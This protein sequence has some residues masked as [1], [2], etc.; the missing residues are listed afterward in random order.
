MM[1]K[2]ANFVLAHP[3]LITFFIFVLVVLAALP[4]SKIR[5]DFDLENFYPDTDPTVQSYRYLEEEFGRDDNI[6]MVGFK[7]STFFTKEGLLQLKQIVDSVKQ[8][9]LVEDVRSVWSA[10]EMV[11]N[12]GSLTIDPF[13]DEDSLA[14]SLSSAKANITQDPFAAGFFIDEG[15]QTTA[16]YIE[17]EEE[18]NTYETR[19]ALINEL[20]TIL[21][22][23]PETDFKITGIP[24]FRN[25][26]VNTL[27]GEVIFYISFSSVLIIIL[28]W[29]LYRSISGV[30][31]PML[32]VWFTVLFTVAAITFT[33]GYLEIMSS[34]IAPILL[35]VGVADSIH[36]ISKFDD[37]IQN[38]FEKSKAI[39]EMLLTLGSATFL[40]SITTAIGFG[41]L[42]TSSVVPMKRFGLYT[43]LGVLIAYTITILFLP[44]IIKITKIDRVFKENG[45]RLYTWIAEK[46][47]LLSIFN[48]KYFK[49][50]SISAILICGLIGLGMFKLNVNG[51]VFDDVSRSSVLIQDSNFFSE[52]LAP[53][54]PLEFVIDTKV[55]SGITDPSLLNKVDQFQAHLLSYPEIKRATSFTT[56][57]KELHETMAPDKAAL[58]TI[59]DNPAL[60]SQY[61][62]LLEITGNDVLSR[63]TDFD[64]QK[65]RIA[66]QTEDAGS[67]RINEI[68]ASIEEYISTNFAEEEI[69]VLITGSTILSANLVG[70]MVYSLA[71]SIGLAFICISILMA[72]LFKDLKMV[73]ISLIPNIMPLVLIAGIMGILG[74]DIKPSTAVIFTIAFGIAVDDT[75]HY[76]AR[77]RIEL[78]R[79]LGIQ[80]A[81]EITTQ[82]TGR[83]IIITSFILLA[84]FGTL[85]TSAFTSTTL[86]GI[87]VAA[88]ILFAVIADLI[89]LPSLFYWLNP[90]L[91]DIRAKN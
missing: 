65:L 60:L 91:K 62:L 29:Y 54:F 85:I 70:K 39:L 56:L 16:F 66:A 75:I 82:K 28:L 69:D 61:L 59:P 14:H 9:P 38:G 63:V 84:G 51:R 78:K 3:R 26:Y 1:D 80:E 58:S 41:T 48:R 79:G 55:E 6:I 33:G 24:Y 81:L 23:Y 40:T 5:T 42:I 11:N 86:M 74:I 25:Q 44:A 68:R 52:E 88:T 19:N 36:M 8:I 71:S 43:A 37:A 13:L 89:V 50:I 76:L 31:I 21:E 45:G 17:I 10:E 87:L 20:N 72:F 77:F 4:A 67:M 90:K 57:I 73:L 12:N 47:S 2:F 22:S 32:I 30:I 15:A 53:A 35:C 27:N 46:L 7:D 34:T 49:T 83:A 18:N 64:Y